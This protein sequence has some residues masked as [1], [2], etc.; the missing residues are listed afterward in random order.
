[1]TIEQRPKGGSVN[2]GGGTFLAQGTAIAKSM[3]QGG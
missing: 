3:G 2:Y 1:M